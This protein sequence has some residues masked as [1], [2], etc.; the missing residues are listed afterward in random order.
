MRGARKREGEKS[1]KK[2]GGGTGE[3]WE[4]RESAKAPTPGGG[5]GEAGKEPLTLPLFLA[6]FAFALLRASHALGKERAATQAMFTRT[7]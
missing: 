5:R 6:L 3:A 2:A 7:I 4:A 1:E